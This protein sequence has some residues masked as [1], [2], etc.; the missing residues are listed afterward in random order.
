MSAQEDLSRQPKEDA[1]TFEQV[2]ATE[3]REICEARRRRRDGQ[4]SQEEN[5]KAAQNDPNP[6]ER[7]HKEALVGLAF[8]GGGIRSATF[9]LGVLQGLAGLRLL[10]KFDYLST[11]SGGGYIGSWFSA[12]IKREGLDKVEKELDPGRAQADVREEA[13]PIRFLRA[14]SN[15]LTPRLGLLSV[16]T[17]AFI[18]IYLRNLLL[19]LTILVA[20]LASVLLFPRA[21]VWSVRQAPS[22]VWGE[23]FSGYGLG[24]CLFLLVVAIYFIAR[25]LA[26]E[27][28]YRWF[29][30]QGAILCVVVAPLLCA[31]FAGA[32][33]L[34]FHPEYWESSWWKWA[35]FGSIFYLLLW[36][37]GWILNKFLAPVIDA[38]WDWLRRRKS[39]AAEAPNSAKGNSQPE[40]SPRHGSSSE[41]PGGDNT[42]HGGRLP[43]PEPGQKPRASR[44][45]GVDEPVRTLVPFGDVSCHLGHECQHL[46]NSFPKLL[47]SLAEARHRRGGGGRAAADISGRGNGK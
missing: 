38:V 1:F 16:D 31:A 13:Q 40:D 44:Q 3:L 45:S 33:W 2:L 8:S 18:A 47:R 37:L 17:W 42:A 11:V 41:G 29:T 22:Q 25:N 28:P 36:F 5:P 19:N 35:A 26:S 15:Y 39:N 32:L 43:G 24:L 20:A 34:W 12:W 7:A 30:H 27:E 9:H 23:G 4:E 46:R 21:L 14:Y 6:Y 10:Q